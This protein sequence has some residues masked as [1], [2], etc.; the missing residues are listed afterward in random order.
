[1]PF[2]LTRF[3]RLLAV[4]ALLA[5]AG[6][7]P[8]PPKTVPNTVPKPAAAG[9][10]PFQ[11]ITFNSVLRWEAGPT[12]ASRYEIS[13]LGLLKEIT[14]RGK[15]SFLLASGG[16][17]Y[18][19]EAG[20]H[21]GKKGIFSG[22][23]RVT[24]EP[25]TLEVLRVLPQ[26][27][28]PGNF[29]FVANERVEGVRTVRYAFRFRDAA[30]RVVWE[31]TIWLLEDRAFP[32]KYVNRGF[33]GHFEIVNS[34]ISLEPKLSRSSSSRRRTSTSSALIAAGSAEK[35]PRLVAGPLDAL[36]RSS[37]QMKR[38]ART[39]VIVES[40]LMST[41]RDGPAV[42]LKGSPTVSPTTAAA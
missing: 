37:T 5:A 21:E 35:G 1:M 25:D 32:V 9:T 20:S 3:R 11:S 42:S 16:N 39:R 13:P 14:D 4:A 41:W 27:F 23:P 40:S 34:R 29:K 33:G 36:L 6:C 10:Y 19:W 18:Q 2:R 30:M 15:V 24:G 38:G 7:N 26:V 28:S 22:G 8:A 31:G 17:A 12:V